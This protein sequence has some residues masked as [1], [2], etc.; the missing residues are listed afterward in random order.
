MLLPMIKHS[1]LFYQKNANVAMS[2]LNRVVNRNYI[3]ISL[4]YIL[5][6]EEVYQKNM[7]SKSK[8][9]IDKKGSTHKYSIK[10]KINLKIHIIIIL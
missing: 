5:Y 10:I 7:I 2:L 9:E 4:H 8:G 6:T 1:V 3:R